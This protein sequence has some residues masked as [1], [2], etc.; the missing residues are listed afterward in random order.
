MKPYTIFAEIVSNLVV[1]LLGVDPNA[2][3][4]DVTEEEIISMVKEAKEPRIL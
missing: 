2:S 4:D 1:R 3:I